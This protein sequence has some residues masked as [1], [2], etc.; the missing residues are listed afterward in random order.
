MSLTG[1]PGDLDY[2]GLYDYIAEEGREDGPPCFMHQINQ[3]RW[4]YLGADGCWWVGAKEFVAGG[5]TKGRLCTGPVG[6][7]GLPLDGAVQWQSWSNGS[8]AWV[9]QPGTSFGVS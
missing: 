7:G 4:V 1:S 2:D 9:A 3:E 8:K 5:L 6:P